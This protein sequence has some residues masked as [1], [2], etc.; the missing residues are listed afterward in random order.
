MRTREVLVR[1]LSRPLEPPPLTFSA[2]AGTM[3]LTKVSSVLFTQSCNL[4]ISLRF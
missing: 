4:R 1:S 3:F 2:A